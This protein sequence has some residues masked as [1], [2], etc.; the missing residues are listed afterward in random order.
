MTLPLYILGIFVFFLIEYLVLRKAL[1]HKKIKRISLDNYI[2]ISLVGALIWPL[3]IFILF[4][5]GYLWVIIFILP[6]P[7]YFLADK[8]NK[9]LFPKEEVPPNDI[10]HPDIKPV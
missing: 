3:T 1:K 10:P 7:F 5:I 4:I 8:I 2:A 9:L 6:I